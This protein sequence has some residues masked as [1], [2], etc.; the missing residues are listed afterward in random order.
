M[1]LPLSEAH[2]PLAQHA[3]LDGSEDEFRWGE[4]VSV[5]SRNSDLDV[6][7]G[8]EVSRDGAEM[9]LRGVQL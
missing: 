5:D 2:V 1:Y 3:V 9:I 8:E 6:V 7:V 4:A